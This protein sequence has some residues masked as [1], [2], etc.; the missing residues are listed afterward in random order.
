ML[1]RHIVTPL[2]SSRLLDSMNM[3]FL[4]NTIAY[5]EAISKCTVLLHLYSRQSP[6]VLGITH[7]NILILILDSYKANKE[8]S[9][10]HSS[11]RLLITTD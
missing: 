7:F 1:P 9:C 5:T 4:C 2:L 8:T 11:T 3:Q 6:L 10:G